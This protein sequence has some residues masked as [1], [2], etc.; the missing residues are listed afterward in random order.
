[1]TVA[2]LSIAGLSMVLLD[3]EDSTLILGCTDLV[4]DRD[5]VGLV[6]AV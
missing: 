2:P 6:H 4:E 1:M 5:L 3:P